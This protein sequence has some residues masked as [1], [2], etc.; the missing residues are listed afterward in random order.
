MMDVGRE[1]DI[2]STAYFCLSVEGHTVNPSAE[3]ISNVCLERTLGSH[4]RPSRK[5][6]LPGKFIS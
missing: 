5:W 4:S 1:W 3:F 6:Q 2:A